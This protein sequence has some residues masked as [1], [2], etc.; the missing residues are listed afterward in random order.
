MKA[1]FI[2]FSAVLSS[3]AIEKPNYET[4]TKEGNFEVRKYPAIPV[5][6][7]PMEE[8]DKRNESFRELF[9]YIS[10]E[11]EKKEKIAMTSPVFMEEGRETGK[12]GKMSF[13]IP[14]KV[15][16]KGAPSPD[17]EGVALSDIEEGNFAILKFKGW[18]DEGKRAKASEDLSKL[19]SG[20]K[21][22]PVGKA[23]F[24]F[25][26][27]PWTPELLRRNEIWQRIEP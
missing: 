27:P 13:M 5:V 6:S 10:G 2:L 4:I 19:I 18:N 12:N 25:Y 20:N 8:M 7:A 22:K 3:C 26:D 1:L 15:S 14:A 11:N 23:F 16:K 21:L 24:A 9:Q 17:A